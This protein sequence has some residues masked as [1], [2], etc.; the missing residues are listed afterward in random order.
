MTEMTRSAV[1][2]F[3]SYAHEDEE[4]LN[5][6]EVHL[7]LLKREG[8][9]RT[10]CRRKITPGEEWRVERDGR[11]EEADLILLLVSAWLIGSDY[12]WE[13][14][15]TKALNRHAR[16]EARVVPI[17]VR[18][19]DWKTAP[20][21]HIQSLPEKSKPV[22]LWGDRDSAWH[23]VVQGLRKTIADLREG[24]PAD[25]ESRI[26]SAELKAL[27]RRR[28]DLT[29]AGETTDDVNSQIREVRRQLR[30]GPQ[31]RPGEFLHDGRYELIET[32]G[33]GG[34]AVVWKAWDNTR[35]SLVALKVLHG[36]Y[37]DDRSRR[38]RFF[39]GAREMAGLE[40]P[41]IVRVFEK[42]LVDDGCWFFYTM[43]F[44][45]E[46]N[47]EQAVLEHR[48]TKRQRL[49]IVLQVGEALAFAHRKGIV[50][51][52]VKPTN[53]LLD[54]A[55]TAKLTDFDLVRAEDT[56]GLTRSRAMMGTLQFAALEALTSAGTAG[57]AADVYSLGSTAVVAV[58]GEPLPAAYFRAP[59]SV[60]AELSCTEALKRVLGRATALEVKERTSSV[61]GFCRDFKV[62]AFD[63]PVSIVSA[64]Q[65]KAPGP[66]PSGPKRRWLRPLLATAALAT[67]IV[68][69]AD[70]SSRFGKP[71]L[72]DT[73]ESS[74]Q[75]SLGGDSRAPVSN[76]PASAGDLNDEPPLEPDVQNP[77]PASAGPESPVSNGTPSP[78]DA[79]TDSRPGSEP[80]RST[81]AEA[82]PPPTSPVADDGK[83]GG[84]SS[85]KPDST[86]NAEAHKVDLA[87]KPRGSDLEPSFVNARVEI[88]EPL[89]HLNFKLPGNS[90][91]IALE[92]GQVVSIPEE[93]TRNR[94]GQVVSIDIL[95]EENPAKARLERI[96]G[97]TVLSPNYYWALD[98]SSKPCQKSDIV[99]D[100]HIS[101]GNKATW[102]TK[103]ARNGD[104]MP[105]IYGMS[106]NITIISDGF[107]EH[108]ATDRPA[109]PLE[110]PIRNWK[111]DLTAENLERDFQILVTPRCDNE[112]NED[113][114][115]VLISLGP[116][117]SIEIGNE[118][119]FSVAY[120][121]VTENA[122]FFLHG[123]PNKE[124]L[125]FETESSVYTIADWDQDGD[126]CGAHKVKLVP[127]EVRRTFRLT[128]LATC[129]ETRKGP[130]ANEWIMFHDEKAKS[131]D[132]GELL[133]T[134]DHKW[135]STEIR[136]A[137]DSIYEIVKSADLKA[138]RYSKV[139]IGWK[140]STI[141]F[142][143]E[144]L[145][146]RKMQM[147][148][149]QVAILD[150][151]E[152][153]RSPPTLDNIDMK[154][155]DRCPDH[156]P[157]N[158]A[159]SFLHIKDEGRVVLRPNGYTTMDQ[160][161][162]VSSQGHKDYEPFSVA[163][164]LDSEQKNPFRLKRR[165]PGVMLVINATSFLEKSHVALIDPLVD[166]LTQETN[167]D[168][169]VVAAHSFGDDFLV[170]IRLPANGK[171]Q[172]TRKGM[173]S[174]VIDKESHPDPIQDLRNAYDTL[175][176]FN[177]DVS[178][179]RNHLIYIVPSDPTCKI[180]APEEVME[181][182][183]MMNI[184]VFEIKTEDRRSAVC[185][186]FPGLTHHYVDA[187]ELSRLLTME[188][189][190]WRVTGHP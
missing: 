61:E 99:A 30:Q 159:K 2:V 1:D 52:D 70:L 56:T 182:T 71:T 66:R 188:A 152:F 69:V 97:Q 100:I 74:S 106:H 51:R 189:S 21:A 98:F 147:G 5:E 181:Y 12:C 155:Q 156:A 178:G 166:F 17:L 89:R 49:E 65:K 128:E 158:L 161:I 185:L 22:A 124:F 108:R 145:L 162:I 137:S 136:L 19:C 92:A 55:H 29:L 117:R 91:P 187:N 119:R 138:R 120:P 27:Y 172:A 122:Q 179:Y 48:L 148:T 139:D 7:A 116:G 8:L 38:E 79:G 42:E 150:L 16:R 131:N 170:P 168:N 15:V 176:A 160:A 115:S 121:R 125:F 59:E 87:K 28:K 142:E 104:R 190:Q 167:L 3:I 154:I 84:G 68:I 94:R 34:F 107:K 127:R 140:G 169:K 33:Q 173:N 9:I 64:Q 26:L 151:S 39:R 37:A 114:T 112:S 44:L 153:S 184:T 130:V 25:K 73:P 146:R 105:F 83:R 175:R 144:I 40:H 90:A 96:G 109:S 111:I 14:E 93:L 53:I 20:F 129:D 10:W 113:T 123:M 60:I 43:E 163:L 46:G 86:N 132:Q 23:D 180:I 81:F 102:E 57:P 95:V 4:F 54:E 177:S 18:S 164:S 174:L 47:F 32:I 103:N 11:L 63:R 88:A 36:Q 110:N 13:A 80:E 41:H 149:R 24:I 133:A 6:L 85:S 101:S 143:P 82:K 157:R 62:A 78:Q 58:S 45:P 134:G 75:V 72:E 141:C 135:R 77:D 126:V 67:L 76:P 171:Q 31:L 165:L 35:R 50:H 118:G 183:R 186:N